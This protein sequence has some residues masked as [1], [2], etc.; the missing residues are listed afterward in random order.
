MGF[1]NFAGLDMLL[2]GND[3]EFERCAPLMQQL[4]G[5]QSKFKGRPH[6][7]KVHSLSPTEL[8]QLYPQWEA[9]LEM[10]MRM[11]PNGVFENEYL[12]N[13]FV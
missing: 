8:R 3:A 5:P 13:L 2:V 9:F 7:G 1:L 6:W 12:R 10:K 11:D 4:L